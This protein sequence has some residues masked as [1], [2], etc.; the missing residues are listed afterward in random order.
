[1]SCGFN[2]VCFDGL[3]AYGL[4]FIDVTFEKCVFSRKLM[5]FFQKCGF[6]GTQLSQSKIGETSFKE[7]S[8]S[9]F[10][11]KGNENTKIIF[12]DCDFLGSTFES[13][14]V[15]VNFV[16]C[17]MNNVDFRKSTLSEIIFVE[18]NLESIMWPTEPNSFAIENSEFRRRKNDLCDLISEIGYKEYCWLVD[19]HPESGI[20]ILDN[21][22]FS[23]LPREDRE[24]VLKYFFDLRVEKTQ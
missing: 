24:I 5:G 23:E 13:K 2:E 12:E 1:L 10:S 16:R 4:I 20:S 8:F 11:Y 3:G 17:K 18:C 14:L 15:G 9:N 19:S 7:C 6:F 21:S 22:F